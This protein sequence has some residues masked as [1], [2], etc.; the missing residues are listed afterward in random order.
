MNRPS[1]SLA[2]TAKPL[3]SPIF[4]IASAP[5]GMESW[6]KPEVLENTRTEKA[7]SPA[8]AGMLSSSS[9]ARARAPAQGAAVRRVARWGM[10]VLQ[11]LQ[12]SATIAA[13]AGRPAASGVAPPGLV[14]R[15]ELAPSGQ[16]AGRIR[17]T[18]R[19][20]PSPVVTVSRSNREGGVRTRTRPDAAPHRPAARRGIAGNREKGPGFAAGLR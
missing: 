11:G 8:L 18:R 14:N 2:V 17:L 5:T 9:P 12:G 6:R 10:G 13:A 7:G 3:A 19:A 4:L 1:S 15:L 16:L 20:R